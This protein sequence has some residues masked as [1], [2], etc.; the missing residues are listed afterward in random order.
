MT[1][2]TIPD[3]DEM[4]AAQQIELMEALWKNMSEKNVNGEPPDWHLEYL[5]ERRKAVVKGEDSFVSLDSFEDDLR[6]ELK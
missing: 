2:Q 3:I 4:T 6:N 5:E 1:V